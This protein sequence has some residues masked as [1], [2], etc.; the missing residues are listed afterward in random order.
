LKQETFI[1]E[2]PSQTE[3]M[4]DA[5]CIHL[6]DE[7]RTDKKILYQERKLEANIEVSQPFKISHTNF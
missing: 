1:N 6:A 5:L 2:P 3:K 7:L 4:F